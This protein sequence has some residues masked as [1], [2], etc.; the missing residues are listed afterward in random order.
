MDD[1]AA[2]AAA[3]GYAEVIASPMPV[4]IPEPA[5]IMPPI[6]PPK[7][8]A[9]AWALVAHARAHRDGGAGSAGCGDLERAG[10]VGPEGVD[11]ASFVRALVVGDEAAVR[12]DV[13][14]F[15]G[16]VGYYHVGRADRS[17]GVRRSR[18]L[19]GDRVAAG[20]VDRHLQHPGDRGAVERATDPARRR[21]PWPPPPVRRGSR[22]GDPGRGCTTS[23]TAAPLDRRRILPPESV[24]SVRGGAR[25]GDIPAL[26]PSRAAASSNRSSGWTAAI[27]TW[28]EPLGP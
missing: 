6:T 2:P 28:P 26:T 12:V 14:R 1:L 25:M 8:P 19:L 16:R 4:T 20:L 7:M 9:T 11:P 13:D 18:E 27:R 15:A 3:A 5:R 17:A 22:R 10:L 24:C 23:L 21:R